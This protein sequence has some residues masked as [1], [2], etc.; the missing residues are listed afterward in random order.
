MKFTELSDNS[1]ALNL[2]Y[3][4]GIISF[5]YDDKNSSQKYEVKI[6]CPR[7]RSCFFSVVPVGLDGCATAVLEKLDTLLEVNEQGKYVL[8][9]SGPELRA[10]RLGAV[11][12]LGLKAEEFPYL[13]SVRMTETKF[14]FISVPISSEDDI[15]LEI[16]KN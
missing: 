15:T 1:T 14:T 9:E 3:E 10:V 13:A 11:V 2:K 4:N 6:K 16:L 5:L 12:A 8:G 7:H